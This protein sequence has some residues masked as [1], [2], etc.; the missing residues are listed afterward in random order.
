MIGDNSNYYNNMMLKQYLRWLP[1]QLG[2]FNKGAFI[3]QID[4]VLSDD[5]F[6]TS[7]P[8][9]GNTW[10]RFILANMKSNGEEITFENIEQYVPD[11]YT[12]K[13]IINAKKKNRIIKTH[14]TLF[15]YYPKTIYIYRDYRDVLIS[16]YYYETSLKHFE[17]TLE[18]FLL[19]KN[20]DKPFGSWKEHVKLALD[21]KK[22]HP[23]QIF[24]LSFEELLENPISMIKS[25]AEFCNFYPKLSIEEINTRCEFSKLKDNETIHAGDFKK[26]SGQNFFREG[27]KGKWE[28]AFSDQ[29]INVLKRDRELIELMEKLGYTF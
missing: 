18:Q 2:L 20:V 14:Q 27:K 24:L 29:M 19:S 3:L 25:I 26:Q 4:N 9:S 6:I 21:F 16:F 8:K 17:G 12:S 28:E 15:K 11:I 1:A 7:Y 22:K 23:D 10:L 13:R 5:L